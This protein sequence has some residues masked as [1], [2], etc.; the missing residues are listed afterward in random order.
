MYVDIAIV[1]G[2]PS[3]MSLT[4]MLSYTKQKIL[5]IESDNNVGG[6]WKTEFIDDKYYSEHSPKIMTNRY[7]YFMKLC[8]HLGA[9]L[10]F[11]NVYQSNSLFSVYLS[12]N[13]IG[14]LNFVDMLIVILGF[15]KSRICENKET[16]KEFIS[17]L[18]STGQRVFYIV[19]VALASTPDKV[20]MQDVFDEMSN[21]PP[22]LIQMKNPHKWIHHFYKF[23]SH[24]DNVQ[25]MNNTKVK[26]LEFKSNKYYINNNIIA[27]RVH[28]CLPPLDLYNVLKSSIS[29]QNTFGNIHNLKKWAYGSYYDGIGFQLHFNYNIEYPDNWCW[30]CINDWNIIII[31]ASKYLQTF[32]KDNTIKKVWTCVIIDQTN[33]STRINKHVYE[34]TLKEIKDEVL[35][36]LKVYPNVFTFHK[37][38]TYKHGKWRSVSHSFSRNKL[39]TLSYTSKHPN[40]YVVSPVN[41]KGIVNMDLAIKNSY[42][43]VKKYYN[44]Y[45]NILQIDSCNK[46]FALFFAIIVL[47]ILRK[48]VLRMN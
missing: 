10:E 33:Y 13:V 2:G 34:C 22:T 16:V 38:I 43:F 21:I 36:Q 32:T 42:E 28:L 20:M 9:Q 48:L 3:G 24:F 15:F 40:L 44:G 1:G 23:C 12:P 17:S 35:H 14:Q 29:L 18:S 11:E 45:H 8:K 4:T 39:G 7:H 19:T 47:F 46:Y 25:I 31:D 5:L 37:G 26:S 6:C 27:S 41:S 30:S